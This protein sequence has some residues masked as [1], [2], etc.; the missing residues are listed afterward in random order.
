[1]TTFFEYNG[2]KYYLVTNNTWTGAQAQAKALGG[3]L[4]TIN[5][6]AEQ[7]WLL[8]TFGGSTRY[9]IGLTD[10]DSEAKNDGSKFQWVSGETSTYRN[11]A[12]GEPN[13]LGN[14]EDYGEMMGSDG[15]W[16]DLPDNYSSTT[17]GIVEIKNWFEYNGSTYYLVPSITWTG[18]QAA[19]QALGGNL[20]TIND[21]A[22]QDWLLK[23]FKGSKN[24]WI[25]LTDKDSEAGTD[26]SKFQWVSGEKSTY[27]N[28]KVGEPNDA[29]EVED[30]AEMWGSDGK[31]NDVPDGNRIKTLEGIVEVKNWFEYNGSK[32]YL[33]PSN[34]WT[35]AQAEAQA[36]A[37]GGNLVTI[38]DQ[39]EQDWL[40]KTFGGSENK[41][42]WIGLT[43]KDIEAGEV[44]SKFQWVSGDTSTYRKFAN[45]EPN[46]SGG[47]ED[48]VHINFGSF[49]VW[50]DNNNSQKFQGIVEVVN[51]EPINKP[52]DADI[53]LLSLLGGAKFKPNRHLQ[54]RK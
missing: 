50:N 51:T 37:L 19:A 39:A 43:D 49:N 52:S 27:R 11:F 20:V 45:G 29:K 22:E 47:N 31:W 14:N 8:K 36:Q 17:K 53:S 26:G 9:W 13:D 28:F 7:D 6:Q 5:D 42:Y 10:K 41:N 34:T 23:T 32:Y 48:Y 12:P 4:V 25:G 18:A 24:Y 15:K 2:S 3:N 16:N 33:V 21:Q 35:G 44:S 54:N 46:D 40:L 38:N 1:M 30:Y